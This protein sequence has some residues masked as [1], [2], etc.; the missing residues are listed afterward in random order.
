MDY[1]NKSLMNDKKLWAIY[2]MKGEKEGLVS[3][4]LSESFHNSIRTN[5]IRFLPMPYIPEN[6]VKFQHQQIRR[7]QAQYQGLLKRG[8]S[9]PQ[10]MEKNIGDLY[11]KF[12]T[13]HYKIDPPRRCFYR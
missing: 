13:N 3:C 10:V 12:N 5:K 2:E 11:Q 1:F 9:I 4:Q 7:I 8:Y 6:L